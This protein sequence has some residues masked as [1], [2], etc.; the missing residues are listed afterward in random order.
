MHT[1][2]FFLNGNLYRERFRLNGCRYFEFFALPQVAF[3]ILSFLVKSTRDKVI[4][5]QQIHKIIPK[6]NLN[7]IKNL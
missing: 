1:K 5:L 2:K 4:N 6:I 3:T 7:L